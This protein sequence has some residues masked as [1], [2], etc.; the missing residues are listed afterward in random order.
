MPCCRQP[1]IVFQKVF[2]RNLAPSWTITLTAVLIRGYN[3]GNMACPVSFLTVC[4]YRL[5]KAQ[6]C[7]WSSLDNYLP[8]S[9][10]LPKPHSQGGGLPS[11]FGGGK[12][13]M[14]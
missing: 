9:R 5:A 4:A 10:L 11:T 7:W 3:R 14:H 6:S 1:V 2:Q 8:A 12:Y 13:P